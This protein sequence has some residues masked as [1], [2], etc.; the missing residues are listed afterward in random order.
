[1]RIRDHLLPYALLNYVSLYIV[2]INNIRH[3]KNLYVLTVRFV[4]FSLVTIHLLIII[5]GLFRGAMAWPPDAITE[6]SRNARNE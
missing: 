5:F 1:M 4:L 3:Y 2:T 6:Q